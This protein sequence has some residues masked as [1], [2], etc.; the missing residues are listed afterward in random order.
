MK[1]SNQSK[2]YHLD[3]SV[4]LFFVITILVTATMFAFKYV[5][6]TPCEVIDFSIDKLEARVNQSIKFEDNTIAAQE[7]QWD[8]GDD[9]EVDF[10]KSAYHTYKKP[11]EYEVS[12]I[13]NG[14]CSSVKKVTILE[15]KEILDPSKKAK[16][17]ILTK[18][19]R[20]GEKLKLKEYTQDAKTWEWS[21]ENVDG[22]TSKE[23]NPEYVYTTSGKKT[24]TLIVNGEFKYATTR[25]IEVQPKK[26][27]EREDIVGI[28]IPNPIP[29]R[30]DGT[31]IP[32]NPEG[33][34]SNGIEGSTIEKP[35][36]YKITREAFRA[37]LILVSE[38][39]ASAKDFKEY[40]CG[41]LDLPIY[42]NKK[43][44]TF[45]EFC[46]K[47]RGKGIRILDLD[48]VHQDDNC[49]K[50]VTLRYKKTSLF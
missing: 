22:A 49:I 10:K 26:E 13:I 9:S 31:R 32:E 8:F 39:E 15:K 20:V 34:G 1:T 14:K 41:N 50:I 17:E 37:Q 4:I 48:L 36:V 33:E 7:W 45:I 11:G 12:L 23:Q 30:T 18:K 29:E 5:N 28:P 2:N 46:E 6:Y 43:R 16:F 35:E 38:K 19:I 47:I 21:F 25:T 3:K 42:V 24:I 27:I 40:F 44:T